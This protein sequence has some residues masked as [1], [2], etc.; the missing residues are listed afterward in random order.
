MTPLAMP[1]HA[2]GSTLPAR[3]EKPSR[4]REGCP[5]HLVT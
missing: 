3:E 5:G 1:L 4:L 2:N